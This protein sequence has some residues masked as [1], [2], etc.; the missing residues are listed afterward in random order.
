MIENTFQ[1]IKNIRR[2]G[3]LRLWKSG[4]L[5]WNHLLSMDKS[6]PHFT[7]KM[8][9]DLKNEC[10]KCKQ[11]LDNEDYNYFLQN[12]P[13]DLLWRFLPNFMGKILYF[14]VEMTGLD[15]ERDTITTIAT[16]DGEKI[17]HFVR[18]QNLSDFVKLINNFDAIATFDGKRTDIPFIEKEFNISINKIHFDL[19]HLSRKVRL[20][21]G[22]KQIEKILKIERG[23]LEDINGK[24]AIY[25]WKE[26]IQTQDSRFLETLL[27]YNI[28]DTI[29]LEEILFEFYVRLRDFEKIPEKKIKYSPSIIQNPYNPSKEI[30]EILKITNN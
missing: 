17:Q 5:S 7:K 20:S 28:E 24:S 19:F 23:G 30:L 25:L 3:E 22:L 27:A 21:G 10:Q 14:D 18:D 26:Y 9:M 12:F 1:H 4:I 11:A 16:Y 29:H 8:W 6:H 2:K 15:I 13:E